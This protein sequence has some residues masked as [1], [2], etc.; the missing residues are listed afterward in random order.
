MP[1]TKEVLSTPVTLQFD[2]RLVLASQI[3]S[4]AASL[5]VFL[6]GAVVLYAWKFNIPILKSVLSNAVAMKVNTAIGL[7]LVGLAMFLFQI[8]RTNKWTRWL[9]RGLAALA[10]SIGL[11][12]LY[13]YAFSQNLGIDQWLF[14]EQP[15]AVLTVYLGR[16]AISAAVCFVIS[17]ISLLLLSRRTARCIIVA[18]T[19]ML[20]IGYISL[21][22]FIGYI[23]DI[24]V[25]YLGSTF[26]TP[27]AINTSEAFFLLFL[28]ILF[29]K[30]EG[31]YTRFFVYSG[32]TGI[33]A[34]RLIP[35]AIILPI[36]FSWMNEQ[37]H[38]MGL[39]DDE[40]GHS[41]LVIWIIVIFIFFIWLNTRLSERLEKER[42]RL[43]VEVENEKIFSNS[44]IEGL[45][46]TF[47]I[48]GVDG[49]AI[50]WNKNTE[51]VSG[52]SAEELDKM[53]PTD[54]FANENKQAAAENIKKGFAVGKTQTEAMIGTKDGRQLPYLFTTQQIKVNQQPYLISWGVDITR[55][56]EAEEAQA[57]SLAE[58]KKLAAVVEASLEAIAI[59]ELDKVNLLRYVN[60]AWERLFGYKAEEVVDKRE[61]LMIE[62]V[63]RDP[64]I[65]AR[66]RQSFVSATPFSADVEFRKKSGALVPVDLFSIPFKDTASGKLL[67]I[68]SIRD[69]TERK[70]TEAK[71]KKEKESSE[72]LAKD[73][74]KF[75]RAVDATSD[76]VMIDDI[77]GMV[78]YANPAVKAVTG[79]EPSEA[80]GKKSGTLWGKHMPKEFYAIMWHIIKDEKKTFIGEITNRRKN[81]EDFISDVHISPILDKDGRV[82][83]FVG[84]ERDV[85]KAKEVDRAKSE[86]VSIASHQ[87]RTP[88]TAIKW[89]AELLARTELRGEEKKY[90]RQIIVSN[91][92]MIAL[93]NDLLDVSRIDTG[94]KFSI[95]PKIINIVTIIKEAVAA[96]SILAENNGIKIKLAPKFPKKLELLVDGEKIRQVFQNLLD[97]AVKYSPESKSVI[98]GYQPTDKE[99]IFYVKDSGIGIPKKQQDR[100]FQRFFRAENVAT[101]KASGTG[102]GLYLVKAVVEGHG[103]RIWFE[104]EEGKGTTFYFSLPL[105]KIGG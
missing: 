5:I 61:P 82:Q 10:V 56:K 105:A 6:I 98:V 17:G 103:G 18:K 16:M 21:S 66:L 9:G 90:L 57:K 95:V 93:V 48:F 28:A 71:L 77:D 73:L 47:A 97:N 58:A 42:L 36:I 35:L 63:R 14:P 81:G 86:F 76:M 64:A 70:Q 15:G 8:K 27:M 7:M 39:Y 101:L 55:I 52:Y 84:I 59:V 11:L 38:L 75:K 4:K 30:S 34:R 19:L 25:F 24:R 67:W 102:L 51:I 1:E 74:E 32:M 104:S 89:Y 12:T 40:W 43:K 20:P 31:G 69:I 72:I 92:R 49:H 78:L 54:F 99:A 50:R 60:P 23:F 46:G 53:R 62:A 41:M 68:N 65:Y 91:E 94:T 83:F 26:F 80:V 33:T 96:E 85:T 22:A 88:L 45:P 87:L 44:I 100:V 2:S 3:F 79:Y 29:F 37:G 13:E